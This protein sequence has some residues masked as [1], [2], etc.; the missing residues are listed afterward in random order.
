LQKILKV[1][2]DGIIGNKT[3]QAMRQQDTQFMILAVCDERLKFLR[4]LDTWRVFGAGWGRRVAGVR[5]QALGLM[6][7]KPL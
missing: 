5:Q 2:P 3:L 6:K 4:G 7:G 1:N